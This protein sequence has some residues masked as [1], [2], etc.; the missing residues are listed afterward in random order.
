MSEYT[1]LYAIAQLKWDSM[2]GRKITPS[3]PDK[4]VHLDGIIS[5]NSNDQITDNYNTNNWRRSDPLIAGTMGVRDVLDLKRATKLCRHYTEKKRKENGYESCQK[6]QLIWDVITHN[7]L[8]CMEKGGLGLSINET[9]RP[10][11]SY[12]DMNRRLKGKKINKDGQHTIAVDAIKRYMITCMHGRRV[13]NYSK[14]KV[15]LCK[16]DQWN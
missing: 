2:Y 7:T 15:N 9:S 10:N 12:S 14:R 3:V 1:T 11:G 8:C 6:Y 16:R 5:S 4:H 13:I